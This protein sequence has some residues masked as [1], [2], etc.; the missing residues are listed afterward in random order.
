MAAPDYY[1]LLG[2]GRSATEKEIK[3]AYRKLARKYHP[4]VNPGNKA[5][6]DK[7]KQINTANEVLSDPEKRRKYD[8]YGENWEQ[9]SRFG[10]AQGAPSSAGAGPGGF[11][12]SYNTQGGPDVFGG[13]GGFEDIFA[14]LLRGRGR[15]AQPTRGQ[16][17]EHPLEVSLE[18]AFQGGARLFQLQTPE[19]QVKQ[20]EVKIPA[21]VKTGS[22]VRIA[23]QG[24][25]GGAGAGDLYLLITVLPHARFQREDDNLSTDVPVPLS[26][27]MLGGTAAVATLTGKLELKIPPETQNGRVFRLKGQGMPHLGKAGR[28]DLLAKVSVV[29]PSALTAEEKELF[30][31]LKAMRK[32]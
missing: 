23:G 13:G 25:P 5:A 28:G 10:G 12:Y 3:A 7:F 21:G 9:A 19:G 6:E 31:R 16:D 14:D 29:L 11:S 1:S 26:A 22:R 32:E 2:I 30:T 4:D 24:G 8:E 27:A 20:I 15:R 17:I 18:E